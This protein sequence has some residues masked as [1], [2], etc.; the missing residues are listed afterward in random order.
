MGPK[1]SVG[2]ALAAVVAAAVARVAQSVPPGPRPG[3]VGTPSV[4]GP[5]V[6]GDGDVSFTSP[7][8]ADCDAPTAPGSGASGRYTSEHT[9][10]TV[11]GT[12]NDDRRTPATAVGEGA[13]QGEGQGSDASH[14]AYQRFLLTHRPSPSPPVRWVGPPG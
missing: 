5:G 14:S 9:G 8:T 3:A 6:D 4:R 12:E 2:P 13:A 11:L 10:G 7:P 1:S